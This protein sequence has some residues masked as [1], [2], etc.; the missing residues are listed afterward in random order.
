MKEETIYELCLGIAGAIKLFKQREGREPGINELSDFTVIQKE[1]VIHLCNRMENF[2]IVSR[3]T[4]PFGDRI[5]LKD[6]KNFISL[7]KAESEISVEKETRKIEKQK[8]EKTQKIDKMLSSD[9]YSIQKKK[10][11]AELDEILKDPSLQ[12]KKNPLDALFDTQ[13]IDEED[14]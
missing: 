1:K 13:D 8:K 11:F 6:L 2:G 7:I 12:R 10:K 5:Y 14:I 3:V 9:S 4:T